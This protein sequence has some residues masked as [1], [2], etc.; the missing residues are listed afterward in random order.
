MPRDRS[1]RPL[2]L[3]AS[4]KDFGSRADVER[5]VCLPTNSKCYRAATVI[6]RR[7]KLSSRCSGA[8]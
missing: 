3:E 7:Y 1:C 4:M 5:D 8:L 2:H 6:D